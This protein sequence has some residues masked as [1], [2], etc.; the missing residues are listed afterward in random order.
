MPIL[1]IRR[2]G[3]DIDHRLR[4]LAVESTIKRPNGVRMV[5]GFGRPDTELG[6][7]AGEDTPNVRRT[8]APTRQ[9]VPERH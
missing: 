3:S 1:D 5:I 7:S 9:R 2:S 4:P 6:T 8:C